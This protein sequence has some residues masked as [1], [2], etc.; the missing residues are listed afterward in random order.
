MNHTILILFFA[1][2][3][4]TQLAAQ[5]VVQLEGRSVTP[6]DIVWDYNHNKI[7]VGQ[8]DLRFEHDLDPGANTYRLNGNDGQVGIIAS[9]SEQ[10][11]LNYVIS[12]TDTE[13]TPNV[14][15]YNV[16]KDGD[17]N[18]YVVGTFVGKADLDP[19]PG[20]VELKASTIYEPRSFLASY[21][22]QGQLRFAL[23]LPYLGNM[24]VQA[25]INFYGI[26][27]ILRVDEVGNLYLLLKP[28]LPTGF[29]LDPGAGEY[30]A[31]TSTVV[32]SYDRMGN[33]RFGYP[34]PSNTLGLGCN[35]DGT[36]Y[37]TGTISESSIGSNFDFEPGS[38]VVT[39]SD[40]DSSSFFFA[41]YT[42]QGS[43]NFVQV[44]HGP[45]AVPAHISG[46]ANGDIY[47]SGKMSGVI[48][49][50]PGQG[51][52]KLEVSEFEYDPAGDLFV[53]KY[54]HT[55]E[56]LTAYALED[57]VGQVS[58]EHITDMEV[59]REGN[60]YLIGLLGSGSV[61]FD[62]SGGEEVLS[63]GFNS[64]GSPTVSFY[65]ATYDKNWNLLK[66]YTLPYSEDTHIAFARQAGCN[67]YALSGLLNSSTPFDFLPGAEELLIDREG[68]FIFTNRAAEIS[69]PGNCQLT[70]VK[71][72]VWTAAQVK[73]YPNPSRGPF[74]IQIEQNPGFEQL[75]VYNAFGQ[76]IHAERI[77]ADRLNLDLKPFPGGFYYLRLASLDGRYQQSWKLQLVK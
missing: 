19:G 63:G 69:G 1:V 45:N 66:A 11:A 72:S 75:E 53:A 61:D 64:A 10:N 4:T 36:H 5:N 29:D 51:L 47:I 7:M 39:I 13:I 3:I 33:F 32:V 25:G 40:I 44:T 20:V 17:N 27:R 22:E 9:Y 6:T 34:V 41:S 57:L 24:P 37:I 15:V 2:A 71:A 77:A 46:D 38:A 30:I 54:S 56:L 21:D 28:I 67:V 50:D 18:L 65:M 70:E 8:A 31:S 14:A 52:E 35:G 58:S 76:E 23:A 62:P 12:I 48:D 74:Q 26:N 73:I 49:F 55:G 16:E 59:D 68:P 43:L 42:P 60:V